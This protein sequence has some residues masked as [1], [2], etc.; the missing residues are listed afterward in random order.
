M[1]RAIATLAT[2]AITTTALH[3]RA[4]PLDVRRV[5]ADAAG[6]LHVDLDELRRSSLNKP[7]QAAKTMA[8][9][10]PAIAKV[11][12]PL[13]SAGQGITV[14]F[15]DQK[16]DGK[17]VSEAVVV[18]MSSVARA[19]EVV[20][21][22]AALA[23]AKKVGDRYVGTD[24]KDPLE[25]TSVGNLIV[26]SDRDDYLT[27]AVAVLQGKSAALQERMLPAGASGRGIFLLVALRSALLDDIK[28][29]AQSD[30]LKADISSLA[31]TFGEVGADLRGT[32]TAV[33]TTAESAQKVK[34]V[35]DGLVALAGL[36][37]TV[38]ALLPH[39]IDT[40]IKVKVTGTTVEVGLTMPTSDLLKLLE[41]ARA[42]SK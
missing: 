27:R 4:T 11:V 18:E 34:S 19:T 12:E 28:K 21:G 39:P 35:V 22:I 25:V 5:P 40:Y 1:P 16:A 10:E 37:D 3:A 13:W 26:V 23:H 41:E 24:G 15:D 36:S 14:W 29:S 9:S 30:L 31:I 32:A 6:V 8:M 17:K 42:K 38:K 20:D 33:M 7:L 2:L